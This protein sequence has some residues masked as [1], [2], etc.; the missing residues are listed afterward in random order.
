V[1]SKSWPHQKANSISPSPSKP[2]FF[3]CH[4]GSL[5]DVLLSLQSIR[6]LRHAFS[7]HD[8]CLL[9]RQDVGHLLLA[10]GEISDFWDIE[11]NV[12]GEMLSNSDSISLSLQTEFDRC[13]HVIGWMNHGKPE[14]EQF[15]LRLGIDEIIIRS[16]HDESFFSTHLEDRFLDTISPFARYTAP[17]RIPLSL[18]PEFQRNNHELRS[19][20]D[21]DSFILV[22]P[23]SGSRHKCV[24]VSIFVNVIKEITERY[25]QHVVIVAG[26]AE[27]EIV[28]HLK[29]AVSED[30]CTIVSGLD[31]VPLAQ[32]MKKAS[33][34][35]GND[36]GITHLAAALGIPTL[37]L[38]GPTDPAHW[39]PRAPWVRV[40]RGP[41]CICQ[42][43]SDVQACVLKPCLKFHVSPILTAMGKMLGEN[44]FS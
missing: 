15:F 14:L 39:A 40:L 32:L 36:S 28:K 31:L 35:I 27:E 38:F 26:Y 8:F 29:M 43:W 24:P 42:N 6:T 18:S 2:L 41:P 37:A 1:P 3:V 20:C 16:P 9:T 23:G 5:G 13:T 12:L 22:H 30:W 11:R 7:N 19:L 21:H 4:P 34:Y 33:C 10:C 17:D 25:H 44:F